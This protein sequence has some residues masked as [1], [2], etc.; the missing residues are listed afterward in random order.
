MLLLTV[1]LFLGQGWVV[2]VEILLLHCCCCTGLQFL[3]P[4][5]VSDGLLLLVCAGTCRP[6]VRTTG[7][8]TWSPP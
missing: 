6:S 8:V 3:V 1:L 5:I 4:D 2:E 7:R